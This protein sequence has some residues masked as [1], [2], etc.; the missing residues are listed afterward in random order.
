MLH[1]VCL[2]QI[3]IIAV[4]ILLFFS[5]SFYFSSANG[6]LSLGICLLVGVIV[7]IVNTNR[8]SIEGLL[9]LIIMIMLVSFTSIIA[10]DSIKGAAIMLSGIIIAG[11]FALSFDLEK[12]IQIYTDIFPFIALFSIAAFFISLFLPS[13]IQ[14]FPTVTN[15]AGTQAHFLGFSFIQLNE[16]MP[17]NY[18]M[19]WEPGAFQTYLNIGFLLEVFGRSRMRKKVIAIYIAAL[20]TTLSTTGFLTLGLN[21]I[22]ILTKIYQGKRLAYIRVSILSLVMITAIVSVYHL[23]TSN[24]QYAVFGK[25]LLV[26]SGYSNITSAQVRLDSIIYPIQAFLSAPL[27]G[28]GIKGLTEYSSLTGHTMNTCTPLNWFARY[29]FVFG[30]LCIIGFYRFVSGLAQKSNVTILILLTLLIS[31]STEAY[32]DNASIIVFVLIGLFAKNRKKQR[33]QKDHLRPKPSFEAI[34]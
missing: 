21:L 10:G 19:F 16:T 30:A 17:R 9:Y 11:L 27:F 1:L 7:F 14:I 25:L 23:L 3:N 8:L 5:S 15:S 28:V 20:I 32:T 18:G 29:G 31:V 13:V 24:I 4:F 6:S 34:A 2:H 12:F 33:E 22:L 26:G